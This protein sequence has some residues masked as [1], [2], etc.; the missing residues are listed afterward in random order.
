[1][2]KSLT[3]IALASVAVITG[4]S[5][6]EPTRG[7]QAKD[8]VQ[9]VVEAY[10][11]D[12]KY[13]NDAP[14]PPTENPIRDTEKIDEVKEAVQAARDAIAINDGSFENDVPKENPE[15]EWKG[16]LSRTEDDGTKIYTVYNNGNP[17]AEVEMKPD[18]T[19]TI[20]ITDPDN[21]RETKVIAEIVKVDDYNAYYIEG[22]AGN[23]YVII[24]GKPI[25]ISGERIETISSLDKQMLKA[26]AQ[27]VKL[28]VKAHRISG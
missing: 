10:G 5:S 18:G 7:E 25:E 1:M 12:P 23:D 20:T 28:K 19:G 9:E 2:K 17:V 15:L 14:L 3:L 11:F 22:D 24:D 16:E 8:K 6:S 21:I 13:G 26:K 27:R 4:C